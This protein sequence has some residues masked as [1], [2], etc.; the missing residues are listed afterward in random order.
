MHGE[1]R[2][3]DIANTVLNA[4]RADETEV[5]VSAGDSALT[6]FANS[7]IHQNV[8]EVGLEVRVRAVVGSRTGVA[9][10]TS[11]DE[12]TL[13]ELAT[14]AV[15][16]ARFAPETPDFH[17]L[18]RPAPIRSVDAYSEATASYS[19][20]QRAR[21]I[22]V[23]C[24]E[25]LHQDLDASGAWSTSEVELAVANSHGVWAYDAR[26][27][28]AFKTVVM[29][30]SSSGYAER[31]AVD[32]AAVDVAAA[33]RE[34]I[35]KTIRSRDPQ[36]LDPGRYT[37]VLEPYAVGTMIDY[38]SYIGLGALSVQEGRSFMNGQVG[39][40]LVGTNISLWDD[41]LD[42]AGVPMAF[43][44]EGVPKRRVDFFARGVAKD[45]VYD[46]YTAGREGKESSG[47]ALPAPNTYGPLPLNLFLAPGDA[48]R[49]ALLAG[50]TRGIWVTRFHYVNVVHPTKA[51]L[52]G[53][54]RDGTFL[55]ENGQITRPVHNLRFTQSVLEALQQVEAIGRDRL[56]LQ[57]EVGGTCVPALRVDGF[58][59]SS[60]TQF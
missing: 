50:I 2:L 18:P 10:A 52:T 19:P 16:N 32:A 21:D 49:D 43:D 35:E 53:M 42:V 36:H 26:T 55:I 33:G 23:V 39:E 17:G 6:R 1:T 28:A 47:H 20:E 58:N 13:R 57:D 12:R 54:T 31:T 22:K 38:L 15:E 11:A 5:V 8:V 29:G 48:D 44:F 60:A 56:M 9:T 24:D 46:S 40:Q 59:F 25:A 7:A 27:H 37:V 30:S 34:A 51:I 4:S 14:T 3:R 41:G 45:V